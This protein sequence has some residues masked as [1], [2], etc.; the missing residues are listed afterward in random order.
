MEYIL[1][2]DVGTSSLKA[3]LY[4]STGNMLY[5]AS[6][7]YHS[8]Y[9][10]NNYVEQNPLTWKEA[11]LFTLKQSGQYIIEKNIRLEAIAVTSQRASVIPVD[12]NGLPLH[13][14]IMWQDKRS[15][16][17]CEQLLDQ[18]SLTEIYHRTG[19]RA[20]P[21]FSAPKMMWLKDESPEIYVKANK[22]LGVQDYVVYL[23]TGLYITDWTQACRTMLMNINTFAWDEDMLK[24]SGI[25]ASK[26]PDLCPPGSRVGFLD[27]GIA[28]ATGLPSGI[29]VIIGG[30][31]QQCAALA[32]NILQPGYAEA[33]TGTGSFV[34]AYSEAPQFDDQCRTLCSA[35]AIPG[36]WI[37]EAGIFNTGSIH[38]WFKEQFYPA[39]EDVYALMN[40]EAA[41]SPVGAN[42]VMMLSHFEGSAAPYWNPLA[43]GLFF[44]LSLGTRRGDL[45]RAILEGI[46]LE[47]AHNISLIE[48]LVKNISVI[49]VAGGL[50]AF[51]LFNQIQADAFNKT[52]IRYDN[53]E[54]SSLGALMSALITLGVYRDYTEAFR[55]VSPAEPIIFMPD[56]INVEKY[57]RLFKRKDELYQ[58]LNQHK[59]YELFRN[60][61]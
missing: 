59:I 25:S 41:E 17:Q 39:G 29:P 48:N 42:G 32:L 54:A 2:I 60:S 5:R 40:E 4:N 13:N 10:S 23:L 58:A 50:V 3:M 14:A 45:V 26:L 6:K 43:K 36:K 7:E 52:V 12:A 44:N 55:A 34:I 30:G 9:G 53:N 57:Q 38:R 31:D 22:L 19:L 18:L 15:I 1:I 8:E 35:A 24:I 46:A 28:S 56:A 11:L 47:I 37:V 27:S 16:A 20:N 49:S 51:N 21:Y 33:N 61:V